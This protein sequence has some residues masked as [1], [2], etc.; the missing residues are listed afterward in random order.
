MSIIGIWRE[1]HLSGRLN[2]FEWSMVSGVRGC[3]FT[4]S[5]ATYG[6]LNGV[7]ILAFFIITTMSDRIWGTHEMNHSNPHFLVKFLVFLFCWPGISYAAFFISVCAVC[8]AYCLFYSCFRVSEC[9]IDIS[10]IKFYEQRLYVFLLKRFG[11][12]WRYFFGVKSEIYFRFREF[13]GK[14]LYWKISHA[15]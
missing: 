1:L 14:W 10:R 6:G 3:T 7:Y 13:L 9:W 5:W 8:L 4:H 2:Q 15:E 11:G 12:N